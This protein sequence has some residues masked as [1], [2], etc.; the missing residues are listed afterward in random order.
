MEGPVYP[1]KL[2]AVGI[3]HETPDSL[4]RARVNALT[5]D[6]LVCDRFEAAT[7]AC[8][9]DVIEQ[10]KQHGCDAVALACT[11]C[12]LLVGAQDSPLPTLNSTRLLARC[13]LREASRPV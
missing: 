11:E 4:T 9:V 3:G 2:D 10:F 13:A 8:F 1:V 5:L 6:E 12:P 7:R